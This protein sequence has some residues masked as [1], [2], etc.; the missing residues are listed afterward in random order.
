MEQPVQA[1]VWMQQSVRPK[2]G[3]AVIFLVCFQF[4]YSFTL[5]T[6]I[7]TSIRFKFQFLEEHPEHFTSCMYFKERKHL[8]TWGL[9]WP[10]A[11]CVP[12]A[13]P[14]SLPAPVG[15]CDSLVTSFQPSCIWKDALSPS[16]FPSAYIFT[17]T[18]PVKS[19]FTQGL[20]WVT[21][22]L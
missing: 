20:K 21:S 1:Q 13:G 18:L 2:G 15:G 22:S 11:P 5:F 17:G 7:D 14:H 6:D 4:F 12:S 10:S 16:A 8:L 19:I 9:V 3:G